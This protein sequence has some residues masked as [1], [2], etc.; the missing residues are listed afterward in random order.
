MKNDIPSIYSL[1]SELKTDTAKPIYFLF[2]EDHFSI[3]NAIKA[4]FS[5]YDDL[6]TSDFDKETINVEKKGNISDVLDLAYTFPF[7]SEK[8]II[9]VKNFE[10]FNNKKQ[11]AEYVKNFSETTILIMANFG[12][13]T[14]LKTEPYKSLKSEGY[15]F[16]A[17]ELKGYELENWVKKRCNKLGFEIDDEN[18]KTL[19]E[20]VGEDKSLL[21]MQL[22]KFKSFLGKN[23]II[24]TEDIKKLSSATKEYS[25]FDLLNAIG[26]GNSSNSL[27]VINNLLD[28]GKDLIFIV[29]M[30][31]KYFSTISHSLELKQK[32]LSDFEAAKEIGVSQYYYINCKKASYFNNEKRLW[33]AVKALYKTDLQLKTSAIDQKTLSAMMLTDIF[34]EETNKYVN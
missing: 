11:F 31:T 27:K 12:K 24:T 32:R 10:N 2:G 13:I 18:V 30:L 14:N 22:Q 9:A 5:K 21:E 1:R 7:G 6:I 16:E 33:R 26:K 20:I 17:R 15:I 29:S 19:I 23:K 8:K 28:H 4:I 34:L 3:N 25:I